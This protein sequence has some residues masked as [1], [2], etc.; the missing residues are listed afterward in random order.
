[1]PPG[2][3]QSLAFFYEKSRLK[4]ANLSPGCKSGAIKRRFCQMGLQ[5]LMRFGA[6]R[7]IF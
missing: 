1:M 5:I 6:G 7:S 4:V 2:S 3:G